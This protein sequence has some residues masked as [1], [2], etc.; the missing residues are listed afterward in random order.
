MSGTSRNGRNEK[1]R[2]LSRGRKVTMPGQFITDRVKNT[3]LTCRHCGAIDAPILSPGSGPHAFRANCSSCAAFVQWVSA[4][5]PEERAAKRAAGRR[6]A[7][8][9]LPASTQQLEYLKALGDSLGAPASMA[10]ASE[11]I[12][13]LLAQK[14]KTC[15]AKFWKFGR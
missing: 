5:T 11:R 12:D 15:R 14:H 6:A 3:P 4:L 1:K 10:E 7:M 2:H 8:A 9:Q 13:L